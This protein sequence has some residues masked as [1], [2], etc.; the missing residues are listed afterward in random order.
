MSK[1]LLNLKRQNLLVKLV[2]L[3][4]NNFFFVLI[5]LL[6]I[7]LRAFKLNELTT[8]GGDQGQD[9]LV[10]KDMILYHKWTL[11]GIKTSVYSF[12][13]GP[14]YLYML[15]P[16][17][18]LFN[19]QSISGAIAA[20]F[21]S[22][23]T[24]IFLY[25]LCNKYFSKR[26]AIISSL[27]FTVSGE[28][29]IYGNTP[30]YQHFLPLFIVLAIYLFL[31]KKKNIFVNLLLGLSLGLGIELHL[32]NISLLIAVFFYLIFVEKSKF[33]N[34]LSY[35]GGIILGL[36]PTIV[37]ELRHNFLNTR[38][39]LNYQPKEEFE[40]KIFNFI[41]QWLKGS[42][43]FY[44]AS[45]IIFGVI[46]L[47]FVFYFLF[48]KTK[49]ENIAKLQKLSLILIPISVLLSVGFSA[50]EPHYILPFWVILLIII[51]VAIDN[52]FNKRIG[53]IIISVLVITN[54]IFSVSR[55]KNNHGYSMSE[56][57]TLKKIDYVG[58]LISKDS[59][60]YPNFN[61]ASLLDS[62]TRAFPIRYAVI[63]NGSIPEPAENYPSNNYLYLV[64]NYSQ[65]KIFEVTTWEVTSFYPFKIGETWDLKD[66][67]YLYRLDRI[68]SSK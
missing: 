37:F 21:Y 36:A 5:L 42:A 65:E 22:I 15:F 19:L 41:N 1:S 26:V 4:K 25:I 64:T 43:I 33:K 48:Y 54:L 68:L 24:L 29:I 6:A 17:F 7:F 60:N 23:V 52:V 38:F 56:G 2:S 62:V 57:W 28:L 55:L 63:I 66:G 35:I 18:L 47:V 14:V 3:F 49:S 61:V 16:F 20:V 46:I 40:L 58:K 45:L 8:F 31:V 53:N 10:V 34:I 27:L 67:F 30:L 9:F 50:Y 51:P 39:I 12:F 11:L 59:L 44:G 32:L 13:Q